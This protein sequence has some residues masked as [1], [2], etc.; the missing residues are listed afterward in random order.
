MPRRTNESPIMLAEKK[1]T[2]LLLKGSSSESGKSTERKIEKGFFV[3]ALS[4][5]DL[6]ICIR[7]NPTNDQGTF[8]L[9]STIIIE[10]VVKW[11]ALGWQTVPLDVRRGRH[12]LS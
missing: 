10:A 8:N 6:K 2:K 1:E 11:R 5:F 7:N 9:N 3:T 4:R 12:Y